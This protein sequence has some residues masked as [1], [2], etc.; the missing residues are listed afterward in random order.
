MTLEPAHTGQQRDDLAEAIRRLRRAAG[1]TGARLAAHAGMSQAKISKIEN[2]RI[3]PSVTDVERILTALGLPLQS[4]D[5]ARLLDLARAANSDYQGFRT[6]L[7]RGL[8]E[9]QRDLAGIESTAEQIR[10]F[11]PCMITG[12][13][14]TPEYARQTLSHPLVSCGAEWESAL[15]RRLERQQAL[16]ER[17]PRFEFVLT[18]AALRFPLCSPPVMALQMDRIRSLTYLD[19]VDVRV[20]TA[21]P[22]AQVP[23]GPLNG[24]TLYDDRLVTIEVHT[25]KLALRDPKDIAYSRETFDFFQEHALDPEHS[26]AFL[27][28]LAQEFRRH[29]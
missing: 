10:F 17:T 11:L 12:L 14:Q 9:V 27:D 1:L 26:R 2:G 25:G 13:L 24:F 6:A 5:S 23:S 4:G 19:T 20:V 3:R 7:E 8:S 21:H 15:A 29:A 16:H 18:E 28:E 22:P